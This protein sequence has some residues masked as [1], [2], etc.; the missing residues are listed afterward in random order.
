MSQTIE[1]TKTN[2]EIEN[3]TA[4]INLSLIDT[5]G[6][7]DSIDNEVDIEPIFKYI[8]LQLNRYYND[9]FGLNRLSSNDN[10][11][12]C[13]VY[14]IE[15]SHN[16]YINIIISLKSIDIKL[17]KSIHEMVNLFPILAK[18]DAYTKDELKIMKTKVLKDLSENQINIY[19]F[20]ECDS[21]DEQ[22]FVIINETFKVLIK[23]N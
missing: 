13:C 9:E 17:M 18:S 12:H 8:E 11:I 23:I 21:E 4:K 14:F 3:K 10:R 7:G 16:G 1:I 5:P 2:I 19:R 15:P 20:T 22:D 6:F